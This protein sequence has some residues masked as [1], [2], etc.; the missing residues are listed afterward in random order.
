LTNDKD[1]DT[2]TDFEKVM[3]LG[4]DRAPPTI[5]ILGLI[6]AVGLYAGIPD[7]ETLK[8]QHHQTQEVEER[9]SIRQIIIELLEELKELTTKSSK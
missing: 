4:I 3:R 9:R 6:I 8:A 2:L 7:V 5:Y 1:P